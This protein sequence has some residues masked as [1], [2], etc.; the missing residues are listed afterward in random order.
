[1]TDAK[2]LQ[3]QLALI[4]ELAEQADPYIRKRLLALAERYERRLAEH[5]RKTPGQF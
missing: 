5:S 4:R 3:E 2:F 1:M